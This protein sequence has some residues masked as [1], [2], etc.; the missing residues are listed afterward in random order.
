[1]KDQSISSQAFTPKIGVPATFKPANS[2]AMIN[3]DFDSVTASLLNAVDTFEG[4][5][6]AKPD[7]K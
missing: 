6:E 1:M 3:I 4:H 7:K 2:L 5:S